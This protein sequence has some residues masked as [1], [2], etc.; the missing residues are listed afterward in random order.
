MRY[1]EWRLLWDNLA[2]VS[3][4]HGLPWVIAGDFKEVLTGDDK[5]GGRAVST[6]RA[7]QFQECL[8][9]S[10]MIDIGFSG[11][12]YTWSNNRPIGQLVQERIDRVFVNVEWNALFLEAWVEHLE[13]G[14]SNH[15]LVKL[16]W[17]RA[18]IYGHDWSFR[19]QP[20]WLPTPPFQGQG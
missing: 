7:L 10:K 9:T 14:H 18:Q 11:A 2:V 1:V 3:K 12:R 8:N 16:H 15:Y 6:Y 17:D 5:F 19:F 4:L 20:M 13:R